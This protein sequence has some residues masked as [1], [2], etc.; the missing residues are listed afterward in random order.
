MAVLSACAL[1]PMAVWQFTGRLLRHTIHTITKE[2]P[3]A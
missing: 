1:Y 2:T 3:T